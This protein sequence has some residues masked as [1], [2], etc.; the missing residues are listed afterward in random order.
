GDTTTTSTVDVNDWAL[1]PDGR[2]IFWYSWRD[3]WGHLYRYGVDGS[4]RNRVTGGEWSVR[5][6][7]H[8]D[9]AR[10]Q[11]YFTANGREPDQFPY[12]VHLYR[13]GFDGSDL[14]LLTPEPGDHEVRISPSGRFIIDT[15]STVDTPPVTVL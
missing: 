8:V 2:D 5:R 15:Y 13:V 10:Q 4:F 12:H 6:I 11:L 1:S 7:V 9:G 3:G 14:T